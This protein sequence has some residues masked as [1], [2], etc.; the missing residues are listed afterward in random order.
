VSALNGFTGTVNL[1]CA[2][3]SATVHITCSLTPP[4]VSLT[5]SAQTQTSVLNITTVAAR[6]D[7][8]PAAHPRGIWFA[9]GGSTLFA[10]LVLCGVPSRRRRQNMTLGLFVIMIASITTIV[11]CGGGSSNNNN[12][13][14]GTPV[15]TYSIT[16]T[17]TGPSTTHSATVKVSV[18]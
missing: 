1:T 6:L 5:G 10:A 2:P 17:G 13:N 7:S 14:Q 9:A 15:G 11:G 3:S 8:A 18:L 4:N 16:V 12:Q